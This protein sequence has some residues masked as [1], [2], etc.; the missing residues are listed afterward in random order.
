LPDPNTETYSDAS[1]EMLLAGIASG[2]RRAFET[3]YRQTSNR[4]FGIC[5]RVLVERAEAEDVLQEVFTT[6]WRKAAQFDARRADALT[7]LAM[8]A[9]NR[10]IDRL[11]ARPAEARMKHLEL[12]D[13][14]EDL[15]RPASEQMQSDAD[16]L[17]LQRCL[18]EL[19]AR[20]QSLILAAFFEGSTYE[21]LAV[22]C[23]FPPGSVKSWI[24]RGLLQ[25]RACLER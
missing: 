10:A 5:L 24:R 4:L 11:R 16:R 23:G 15:H 21:E 2:S 22:R 1:P 18:R 9:R 25:L 17:R 13:D 12:T 8:I 20:R 6:V 3:L 14:V 7:W 19:D